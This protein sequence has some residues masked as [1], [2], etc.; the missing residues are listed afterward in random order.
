MKIGKKTYIIGGISLFLLTGILLAG[1]H[2][3]CRPGRF[4]DRGF[5]KRFGDRDF[6]EH[7]LG[8]LDSR[9]ANLNL[10]EDQ[11]AKYTDIRSKLKANLQKGKEE[12]KKFVSQLKAEINR[13]NRYFGRSG[14]IVAESGPTLGSRAT[15]RARASMHRVPLSPRSLPHR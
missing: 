5:H 4:C 11:K 12:R 6:S 10:S 13:E 8:R 3:G 9:V 7:I 14:R 15:R 2:A 1:I